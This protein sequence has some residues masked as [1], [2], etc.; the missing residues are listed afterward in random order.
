M[1][2][3]DHAEEGIDSGRVQQF[4]DWWGFSTYYVHLRS[5]QA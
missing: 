5:E 2:H 1:T 4:R 3:K